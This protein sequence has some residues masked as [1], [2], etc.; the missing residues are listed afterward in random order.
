MI[1]DELLRTLA[2]PDYREENKEQLAPIKNLK[3]PD[4][5][6]MVYNVHQIS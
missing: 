6:R 1:P 4:R 3:T 2:Q 5:L